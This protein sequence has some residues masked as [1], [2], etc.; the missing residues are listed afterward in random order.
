MR[1]SSFALGSF[2]GLLGRSAVALTKANASSRA[3][4]CA[5]TRGPNILTRMPRPRARVPAS[6]RARASPRLKI[7]PP[8]APD[9]APAPRVSE[10][11]EICTA[12][13]GESESGSGSRESPV[14]RPEIR[15]VEEGGSQQ[16][17]VDPSDS[18]TRKV[19]PFHE[20]EHFV[21][22]DDGRSGQVRESPK[23]LTPTGETS[24]SE[25]ALHE[26]MDEDVELFQM[27]GQTR[28]AGAEVLYPDGGVDEDAQGRV[29]R[30]VPGRGRRRRGARARG[31]VPPSAASR[32]ALSRTISDSSPARTT[33]AFSVSPVAR[34]ARSIKASSRISVVRILINMADRCASVKRPGAARAHR[35]SDRRG[36]RV[37]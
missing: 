8:E 17:N 25:L 20:G 9:F 23:D 2:G 22:P 11:G 36:C 30:E 33:A 14:E 16:M 1:R 29:R 27:R 21:V 13:S 24:Q 3:G 37:R 19:V 5:A 4:A 18:G 7:G 10:R 12:F 26:R 32:R 6:R 15:S 34:L 35:C 31:S 28:A